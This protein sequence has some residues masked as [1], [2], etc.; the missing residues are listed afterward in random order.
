MLRMRVLLTVLLLLSSSAMAQRVLTLLEPVGGEIWVSGTHTIRWTRAGFGWSGSETIRIEYSS[1]AGSNFTQ[2]TDTVLATAGT[3]NWNVT[4]LPAS[5]LYKVRLTCVQDAGATALSGLFR[6]GANAG[7]YVNDNTTVNDVYCSAVGSDTNDGLSPGM[8]KATIQSVLS[9]YDLE[10]GDTVYVDTGTY[11]LTSN[12]AVGTLD[13]GNAGNPVVLLGSTHA[14][15]T[16]LDRNDT[17]S[18]SSYGI[19]L[20]APYVRA[21]RFRV[22]RAK[23]G[24]MM[25]S[26]TEVR[27]CEIFDSTTGVYMAGGSTVSV[28]NNVIRNN[29]TGVGAFTGSSGEHAGTCVNNTIV[30]N[31]VGLGISFNGGGNYVFRNNI[32]HADGSGRRCVSVATSFIGTNA[33]YDY[34]DLYANNGAVVGNYAGL[35]R[36][37]LGEWRAATGKDANSISLDPIFVDAAGNDY[38]LSSAGGSWHGG[39]FTADAVSSSCIDRGDPADAYSSESSPNG[40]RI[41]LGAYGGTSQASRTPNERIL[42]L[43]EPVGGEVWP[44]GARS[45]RWQ[46]LGTGW[47]GTETLQFEYSPD[48]GITWTQITSSV[49]ATTGTYSWSITGLP[50]SPVYRLR[51]TCVQDPG[52]TAQSGLFRVGANASFYVNDNTTINDVYCSAVGSDTNDGLSPGTPKATIQ[53]VLNT[54]DLEGGDTVYVDTGTYVLTSNV[55]VGTLDGGNAGNPIVLLGSTH[56]DGTTLDR[57][58]T[59]SSSS[60]GIYLQAPYARAERFRV[61]RAKYGVMMTSSTEVRGCEIFD[62]GTGVYMTGG[63]TVSVVNNVIRNNGTGVYAFTGSSGEHAGTC[64]NNTIVKNGIG[65]SISFNG[66]GNYVFRNNIVHADGS[67]RRC[68]SVAVS[69]IGTNAVYDYNDL[70]ANNGAVVGNYAGLDRTTLGEWRAATGKDAN[71]ISLDPIFVDSTT[72]DF[73]LQIISPCVNTGTSTDPVPTTDFEGHPRPAGVAYDIGADE[74]YIPTPAAPVITTDGGNGAGVTYATNNAALV[75]E[76]TC[77]P[78]SAFIHV[79]GSTTGVTYT[80]G[81]TTWSYS[82]TLNQGAN[83]LTVIAYNAIGSVSPSDTITITVDS[84]SPQVQSAS[85]QGSTTVRV[86]FNEA[87][88]NNADLINPAFYTFTGGGAALTAASVT[89]INP[90]TVDVTV[91][92]M[93]NGAGYGVMVATASPTDLAGNHVDPLDNSAG[94]VGIGVP[95]LAPIITTNSGANYSTNQSALTLNGTCAADSVFIRV[96]ASTTGVTYTSGNTTWSYGGTLALEGANVFSVTAVDAAGNVSGADSITVTLDTTPAAAPVIT[97]NSGN[98]YSTNVSALTLAGTCSTDT[99]TIKVNGSTTG[100]NRAGTSWTYT[101]TLAN[102]ANVLTITAEDA[103]GNVS[104][105][106]TITI[107]LDTV[108]PSAPVITT[109]GGA[110]FTTSNSS[111]TLDGTCAADSALIRVNGSASGVTYTPGATTWSYS[112]TLAEGANNF[113]V[114]AVDAASNVSAADTTTV[115]YDPPG[116]ATP[117][118]TTNGGADYTTNQSAITLN[119]TCGTDAAEIRVNGSTTGV[120][121]TAGATT[122]SYTGTL[123]SGA[124]LFTVIAYDAQNVPSIGADTITVTYDIT[125]P[126]VTSVSPANGANVGGASFNLDVTFSEPV[127]GSVDATDAVLSGAAATGGV[128]GTVSNQGGN[129]WRFPVS[130]LSY[131]TLNVTLA[132]DANDIEDAAGNDLAPYALSYT[133]P[134]PSALTEDFETGNFSRL[135]WTFSGN[136]N[137]AI[138]TLDK[139]G[140]TYSA[141]AGTISSSQSSTIQVIQTTSAGNITFWRKVSSEATYDKLTFYI[142]NVSKATWSGT[143]AWS[144]LSY[145]VTAG[146]HTFKWTYSKDATISSGSD[147][148]WID[149]IQFPGI[150]APS[151]PVITTNGGNGAGVNYA[152]NQAAITL[153]GTCSSSS[154]EI[155]VNDSTTGV[156]YVAGQT[157]WSY[158][159]TLVLGANLI[160]VVALNSYGMP[161]PA[162]TITVTYDPDPPNPPVITTNGGN[163]F[164]TSSAAITLDGTC[165]SDTVTIR[166][167]GSTTGVTYIASATSWSYTGTLVEGA[168]IFSVTAADL[169]NVSSPDTITVTL[170]SPPPAPVITTNGGSNYS[171]NQS[172]VTFQGS[173]ASETNGIR[174]NGSTTG[175]TYTAGATTWSYTGTLTEGANLYSVTAVDLGGNASTP[176]TITVTLDSTPPT[177][178]AESPTNGATISENSFNLEVTFSETVTGVDATDAVLSGSAAASAVVAAASNRGGNTWRFP[179]SNLDNGTLDISL[180]PDPGDIEDSIGNDLAP[181]VLNYTVALP[182]GTF[183]GFETGDFT[184]V[185]WSHDGNADWIITGQDKH[186]GSYSARSGIITHSQSTTLQATLTCF[187][188]NVR[189]WRKI[190]SETTNDTLTFYVD[191]SEKGQWSGDSNWTQFTYPVTAG[192]HTFKWSYAKNASVNSLSDAGWIDDIEFPVAGAPDTAPPAPVITTNGGNNILTNQASLTLQGTCGFNTEEIQVNGSTTGVT[193][194]AGAT[195]WSYNGTLLEGANA[196]SVVAVN[197]IGASAADSISVTLDTVAP[198]APVITTNGGANFT[199]SQS[200][201]TLNG[202]CA[203]DTVEIRANGAIAG[204]TYFPGQT[205]W[206]YTAVLVEGPNVVS[207]TAVDAAT[208]ESAADAITITYTRPPGLPTYLLLD[209]SSTVVQVGQPVSVFGFFDTSPSS[210]PATVAGKPIRLRYIFQGTLQTERTVLVNDARGFSDNF[211]PNQ[212]GAWTVQAIFP[213]GDPN[214]NASQAAPVTVVVQA[215]AGYAIIVT[216]RISNNSG[217]PHHRLTIS[218]VYQNLLATGFLE[219]HILRFDPDPVAVG[220]GEFNLPLTESGIRDKVENWARDRMRAAAAPLFIVLVNHGEP[221]RFHVYSGAATEEGNII[222][223][224]DLDLW[225]DNLANNLG[226]DA[227]GLAAKEKPVVVVV[228]A[229]YTG[230]FIPPLLQSPGNLPRRIVIASASATEL[231]FKGPVEGTD[232][233]GRPIRDGELFVTHL[234]SSL[235]RGRNLKLAF[236]DAAQL[237]VNYTSR[238]GQTEANT[239]NPYGRGKQHALLND[240]GDDLGSHILLPNPPPSEDGSLAPSVRLGFGGVFNA[241]EMIFDEVTPLVVLTAGGTEAPAVAARVDNPAGEAALVWAEVKAPGFTL[242]TVPSSEQATVEGLTRIAPDGSKTL[243]TYSWSAE[244]MSFQ[245]FSQPGTYEINYFARNAAGDLAPPAHTYVYRPP[246]G[247]NETP[248]AFGLVYPDDGVEVSETGTFHWQPTTDPEGGFV[249]YSLELVPDTAEAPTIRLDGL[250]T[251]YYVFPQPGDGYDHNDLRDGVTYDWTVYAYD[252]Y[253]ARTASDTRRLTVDTFGNPSLGTGNVLLVLVDALDGHRIP[254]ATVRVSAWTVPHTGQGEYL[255]TDLAANGYFQFDVTSAPGYVVPQSAGLTVF[256]NTV[257]SQTLSLQPTCAPAI[258]SLTPASG[259]CAGGES[260]GVYGS[261]FRAGGTRVWFGNAEIPASAIQFVNSNELQISQ[262]PAAEDAGATEDQPAVAITIETCGEPVVL[263]GGYLY[264]GLTNCGQPADVNSDGGVNA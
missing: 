62:S 48:A 84:V 213:E 198:S 159:G 112:G 120:T 149:D 91:N 226:N 214:L 155:R 146:S 238:P 100:V 232:S 35:D 61:R 135:P 194:A 192:S 173:C 177:I 129:I 67:G 105:P 218:R 131:G 229:C 242:S 70:Y 246:V 179:I 150:T 200:N 28:M 165:A 60:Y 64:V 47:S 97:T 27:G 128:V 3:Y 79:N 127:T 73:H 181:V 205:G 75:L 94:F 172:S 196:F 264:S 255:I 109:N 167:N 115:T 156:T 262:A 258:V 116:T 92:E 256:D 143:V 208:N 132:P 119:G 185:A 220:G 20:Q 187:A 160:S 261:D 202:T 233:F 51:L 175:V 59:S 114:T 45:I 17:S 216:G 124:N 1:D 176:D 99:T 183:E 257:V 253:G 8:P 50:T 154:N 26:S 168:N 148:A 87:M 217:L 161:S 197:S 74:Y 151:A 184:R 136:A 164:T 2:L 11:V 204:V 58:D 23:Y 102:G 140:G 19:Y 259:Q 57:N 103:A 162:D 235:G 69:F 6:V 190:S 231:S 4:G 188:G 206:S 88:T 215:V 195:S 33:V 191:S 107:T 171:T 158:S 68:V 166:V 44:S 137:W 21:E 125:P 227:A 212:P 145:A 77:D 110:N 122:W 82:A 210:P 130:N 108:P 89:R 37:T 244:R 81:E 96:N 153:N 248:D 209:V 32:I 243:D 254:D 236:Q 101:G 230:T 39:S 193:Y 111:L 71:S 180:A 86:V 7:F 170:D 260:V 221:S 12:V 18:S 25:T 121:Y 249:T 85:A 16:T 263:E 211:A 142:D 29:G 152:T 123:S 141:K 54:Y 157:T 118:I 9:T 95:P 93:T 225:L 46:R 55:A 250:T 139:H 40:G 228:G 239:T 186:T 106:D 117:A 38:H 144:Q 251:T 223:P 234:F 201:L 252:Q 83:L 98:N 133:V 237:M 241:T 31:S 53:S 126:T 63:S 66:G 240:N 42:V 113:S 15:G 13:G 36:T 174:V 10:G 207:V 219:E 72:N 224:A 199:T 182:Q 30:K 14:D 147:T 43:L 22:R 24:V 222:A 178:T 49:L 189:F 76:G 80:A 78:V 247:A 41:N 245:D 5:L 169:V 203:S 104:T 163:N 134:V 90:T 34:N 138:T 56:A 52:A 65:L